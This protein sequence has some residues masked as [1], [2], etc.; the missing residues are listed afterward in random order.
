MN[1]QKTRTDVILNKIKNNKIFAI[2]IVSGV[3]IGAFATFSES[4]HKL[5]SSISRYKEPGQKILTFQSSKKY[6]VSDFG[7]YFNSNFEIAEYENEV[8]TISKGGLAVNFSIL[9]S[10]KSFLYKIKKE[11]DIIKINPQ[12]NYL[13]LLQKGG[14]IS[15]LS[16]WN[17]PFEFEFPNLDIKIVNNT[18]KTI[19]LTQA[20]FKIKKSKTDPFPILLIRG[21]GYD[22]KLPLMNIGWGNVYDCVIRCN[23]FPI[24]NVVEKNTYDYEIAIGE[25]ERYPEKIDFA[26]VFKELGVDVEKLRSNRFPFFRGAYTQDIIKAFGP[27]KDGQVKIIGEIHYSG[28]NPNGVKCREQLKFEAI[29]DLGSPGEGA[30]LPPSFQYDIIFKTDKSDYEETLSIS[31][32]IKL[33]D[34]D[35]FNI[36]ISA[37]KSS[38]HV[39]DL[40]LLYNDNETITIPN[41][42]LNYF[43]STE[44]ANFITKE[45]QG[46]EDPNP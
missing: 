18:Q 11:E 9:S 4:L 19:Y 43:M 33:G 24:K 1:T 10:S 28:L 41:I 21:T 2:L 16:Y 44:D 37:L 31:H 20:I 7:N 27:F 13:S 46:D 22:M 32:V 5:I 12:N 3:V 36:K 14:P 17:T 34:A 39:F 26:P 30:P 40:I 42:G 38:R 29:I 35:R 23:V 15:P 25:F 45:P 6:K 8:I